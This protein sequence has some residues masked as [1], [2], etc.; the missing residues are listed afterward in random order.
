[1]I[2]MDDAQEHGA[3][4]RAAR[5]AAGGREREKSIALHMSPPTRCIKWLHRRSHCRLH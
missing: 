5:G 4:K 3:F 1:M 2:E